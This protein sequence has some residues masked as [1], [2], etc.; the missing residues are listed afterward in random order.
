MLE[1]LFLSTL[2]IITFFVFLNKRLLFSLAGIIYL[3]F[4]L[5]GTLH[6]LAYEKVSI[7]SIYFL[8]MFAIPPL[9]LVYKYNFYH[10]KGNSESALLKERLSYVNV[11]LII[12]II[13]G[14]WA[15]IYLIKF[16]QSLSD[17][18]I[19]GFGYSQFYSGAR[20]NDGEGIPILVR[21][22]NAVTHAGAMVTI[23][24]FLEGILVK[25]KFYL[26]FLLPS[27]LLVTES[28]ILGTKSIV[29]MVMI[30]FISGLIISINYH[31]IKRI[32]RRISISIIT[33][34]AFLLLSVLTVHYIRTQGNISILDIVM[35]IITSYFAVP[36]FALI[37]WMN[38]DMTLLPNYFGGKIFQGF[39]SIFSEG[40]ETGEFFF[41]NINGTD[42]QTNVYTAYKQILE[43]FGLILSPLI[44]IGVM[45]FTIFCQR[46]IHNKKITFIPIFLFISNFLLFSFVA[47]VYFFLTNIVAIVIVFSFFYIQK[48]IFK[49]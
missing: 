1:Y 35:K 34:F 16:A 43:D 14:A 8:V 29:I 20:Y 37:D 38:K 26:K 28:I 25:H 33:I 10:Q 44:F 13:S 32:N 41:M 9:L 5:M 47:S 4:A 49:V 15:N 3:Y 21:A 30:Y 6:T 24:F 45:F 12:S 31:G 2:L 42:Y 7:F 19:V 27:L 39:V 22:L 18:I 40:H 36:F 48:N 17:Q 46:K 11:L 23:I